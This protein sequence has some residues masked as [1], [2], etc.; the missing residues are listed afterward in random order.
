MNAN[1]NLI[2]PK[3]KDFLEKQRK[4]KI[5]NAI[6]IIFPIIIG[7]ISLVIFL[8]T[9]AMNPVAIRKQQAEITNKIS[10]LQSKKIKLSIV[11][12]RLD[13]IDELLK[14][15]VNFAENISRLL[16]ETP[17]ELALVNLEIDRNEAILTFNSA[18]LKSIDQ[19]INNLIVMAEKKEVISS[20]SLDSLIFYGND[21]NYLVALRSKL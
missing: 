3:D 20:L 19:F 14:K 1:I 7:A 15:R 6:A 10:Q 9:Q 11:K 12:D 5:V 18:S 17:S 13:N 4:G 8:F 16:S 2:L 21:N